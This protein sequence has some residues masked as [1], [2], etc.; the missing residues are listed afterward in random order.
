[1]T[2]ASLLLAIVAYAFQ[3]WPAG[4]APPPRVVASIKPVHSLVAAV[5]RGVADPLLLVRGGGSPHGY[6]LKPSQARALAEADLIFW[7]GEG[8]EVFLRAPL[9]SLGAGARV[10][11]LA[12][13]PGLRLL[14]LRL[15]VEWAEVSDDTAEGHA[16]G[17]AHGSTDMHFWL[18]PA[19][20]EAMT[21]AILVE[22]IGLDGEREDI[23]REN[24]AE[25]QR[26]LR[27]LDGELERRLAPIAEVPYLVFHDAFQYLETRYRLNALGSVSLGA[28]RPPGARR[29]ASLRR[30]VR[31]RRV[32]CVFAEPQFEPRLLDAVISGS[33]AGSGVLD[34]LGAAIADGP[35]LYFDLMRFN[36]EALWRCLGEGSSAQ[37]QP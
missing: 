7:I 11:A 36:A 9:E 23:Y 29:L 17:H 31:D 21:E 35:A 8:L 20:A 16:Q 25:V 14:P 4:S 22:L 13:S 27:L 5:M 30:L 15:D 24:A 18:D 2:R 34:P 28:D 33:A 26:R 6:A 1:M 3:V 19:N 37:Q 32:R 12:D 10:A